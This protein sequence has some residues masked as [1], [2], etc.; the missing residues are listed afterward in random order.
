MPR[1]N[2]EDY[3]QEEVNSYEDDF[4]EDAESDGDYEASP[5]IE[6][7]LDALLEMVERAK[8]MPLSSSVMM[9]KEEAKALILSAKEVLP[10]EITFSKRLLMENESL[11]RA[12]E[13]EAEELIDEARTQAAFL[14]QR[15]EIARQAR[16]HAE[17]L[18]E[19]AQA[20]ARRIR[21]EAEDYVDRKLA[22]FE[23]ILDKTRQTVTAG[24]ERLTAT[25]PNL[26]KEP[27]VRE[28]H[29]NQDYQEEEHLFDQD[30]D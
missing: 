9:N 1:H 22:A 7:I 20:V 28:T 11:R 30:M 26:E 8:T 4:D 5:S 3:S 6:D 19:D 18:V 29:G 24:R 16:H 12:A 17:R 2:N 14:V 25:L 13:R 23:I 10:D 21:H 15:T 27:M